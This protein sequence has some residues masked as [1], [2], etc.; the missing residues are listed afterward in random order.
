MIRNDGCYNKNEFIENGWWEKNMKIKNKEK[1]KKEE[2]ISNIDLQKF[3]DKSFYCCFSKDENAKNY[4]LGEN[5]LNKKNDVEIDNFKNEKYFSE[6]EKNVDSVN[7]EKKKIKKKK[8]RFPLFPS[9]EG[10]LRK[11]SVN[12]CNLS[13]DLDLGY[14]ESEV[15]Q[16]GDETN[17]GKI[18]CEFYIYLSIN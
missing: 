14:I 11:T 18:I 9:P 5:R 4:Y 8:F 17:E 7:I 2:S 6:R 15:D 3:N 13:S 10:C 1:M 16:W 12:F